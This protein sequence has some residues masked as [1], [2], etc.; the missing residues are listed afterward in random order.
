MELSNNE[1]L[2]FLLI[3]AHRESLTKILSVSYM[4]EHIHLPLLLCEIPSIQKRITRGQK[5]W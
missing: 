2:Y 5:Q 1:K 4:A 3:T